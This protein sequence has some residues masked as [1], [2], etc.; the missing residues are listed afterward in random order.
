[1]SARTDLAVTRRCPIAD[2]DPACLE[3]DTGYQTLKPF[4]EGLSFAGRDH[5]RDRRR[6]HV[7]RDG[8]VGGN[9]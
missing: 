5:D 4:H 1:M 2:P 7:L 8:L 3:R 9:W 6:T